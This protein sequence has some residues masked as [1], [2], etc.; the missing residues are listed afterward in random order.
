MLIDDIKKRAHEAFKAGRVIEKEVLRVVLGE[1]QTAEARTGT[2][3]DEG[4]QAVVR[5]LIK[6]NEETLSLSS[7]EEQKRTLEEELTVLRSLLPTSPSRHRR[8]PV[9]RRGRGR[10]GDAGASLR[11][12]STCCLPVSAPTLRRGMERP[13][14]RLSRGPVRRGH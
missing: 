7:Q 10:G 12:S 9:R 13:D 14:A 8:W 6:S 3:S 4:A 5:R 2:S 11:C 1:I